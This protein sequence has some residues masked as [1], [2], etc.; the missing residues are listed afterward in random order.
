MQSARPRDLGVLV[1]AMGVLLVLF[2]VRL[3]LG[4]PLR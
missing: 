2:V 4:S 1:L 3:T